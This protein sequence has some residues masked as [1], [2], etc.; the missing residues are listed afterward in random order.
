MVLSQKDRVSRGTTKRKDH[1][2]HHPLWRIVLRPR[3]KFVQ[4]AVGIIVTQR[5]VGNRLH[6]VQLQARCLAACIPL[7]PSHCCLR[8]QWCQARAHWRTEWRSVVFSDESRFYIGAS[9]GCVMV[10][11]RL[12][13]RLQPNCLRLRHWIYTWSHG[14]GSNFL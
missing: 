4:V 13:E 12:G 7:T 1:R 5:T 11:R 2:I 3:Q 8:R 10:R 6:Q 9:D 14:L